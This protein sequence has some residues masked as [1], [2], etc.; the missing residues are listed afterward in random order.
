MK[1]V[2][3]RVLAFGLVVGIGFLLFVSVLLSSVLSVI[4]NLFTDLLPGGPL[5]WQILEY[6]ISFIIVTFLFAVLFKVLPDAETRWKDI[7]VGAAI[8]A[9]LFT[10]GRIALTIYMGQA[11]P[12][13]A[14]G[15]AG[16]VIVFLLWVYY[17][18][19]ILFF[20]AEFT[21]VY[22]NRYGAGIEPSDDAVFADQPIPAD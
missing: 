2:R 14:Y 20:G 22:A 21:Q 3:R 18:A 7:W 9:A 17:S 10:I 6:V 16:S 1:N 15:A 8:T 11:A 5:L 12:G 4:A 19:L 13:S